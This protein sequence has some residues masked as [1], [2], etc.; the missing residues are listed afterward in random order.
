MKGFFWFTNVHNFHYVARFFYRNKYKNVSTIIK[1]LLFLKYS[2]KTSHP[3]VKSCHESFFIYFLK[4]ERPNQ[5]SLLPIS[6]TRFISTVNYIMREKTWDSTPKSIN[7]S[8]HQI[9]FACS[10]LQVVLI[11]FHSWKYPRFTYIFLDL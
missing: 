2:V 5:V 1:T 7:S 11:F 8:A 10:W 9:P 3:N 4:I 6:E